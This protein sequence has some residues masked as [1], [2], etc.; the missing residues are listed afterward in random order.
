[1]EGIGNPAFNLSSPDLVA[2]QTSDK[3]VIRHDMLNHT[4]AAHRQKFGLLAST[5]PEGV[6]SVLIIFIVA[7]SCCASDPTWASSSRHQA[8]HP[9]VS[10]QASRLWM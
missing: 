8:F 10:A 5:E 9:S 7:D 2:H 4:L 6:T 1:M 3:R